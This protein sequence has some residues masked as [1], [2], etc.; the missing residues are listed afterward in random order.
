MIEKES[1]IDN[2]VRGRRMHERYCKVKRL[3]LQRR[4]SCLSNACLPILDDSGHRR[5][6]VQAVSQTA[7]S[8][9]ISLLL[10][11]YYPKFVQRLFHHSAGALLLCVSEMRDVLVQPFVVIV[12]DLSMRQEMLLAKGRRTFVV[13]W[14]TNKLFFF[15][16]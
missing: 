10:K 12:K 7:E 2:D 15:T 9:L 1:E 13:I 14:Y 5:P 6:E 3:G 11:R 4:R 8:V 16:D